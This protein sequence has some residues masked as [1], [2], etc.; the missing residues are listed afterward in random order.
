MENGPLRAF[1]ALLPFLEYVYT[2]RLHLGFNINSFF[3]LLYIV[4]MC[5]SNVFLFL[6]VIL[7]YYLNFF[8]FF[9]T[10]NK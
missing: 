9:Y 3:T 5:V 2:L 8:L 6:K 4:Y 7:F 1:Y 10:L